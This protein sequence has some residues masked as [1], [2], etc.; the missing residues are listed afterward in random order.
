MNTRRAAHEEQ[1]VRPKA[2]ISVLFVAILI[3]AAASSFYVN[4]V[5]PRGSSDMPG[6]PGMKADA[7]SDSA[8]AAPAGDQTSSDANMPV[9][10]PASGPAPAM[11][12]SLAL[13]SLSQGED[14]K[15]Q[16]EQLHGKSLGAGLEAAWVAHYGQPEQATLWVSRSLRQKDADALLARMRER[17]G[18]GGSPFTNPRTIQAGITVNVLDGMGQQHF[19]FELDKDIY[20]LAAS[21]E[22]GRAILDE[23]LRDAQK[24]E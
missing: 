12:G 10:D 13:A 14:A 6:M 16:V 22:S 2:V 19:Y 24:K 1:R 3:A 8:S 4:V 11:L 20:W 23:L 21:P 17:I 7:G 18:E 9:A 15:A 5:A